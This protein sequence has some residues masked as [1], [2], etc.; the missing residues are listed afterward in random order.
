MALQYEQVKSNSF[1]R[2]L[3]G[4][5]GGNGRGYRTNNHV[6][7]APR[8]KLERGGLESHVH[9][10]P[11]CGVHRQEVPTALALA[12][13]CYIITATPERALITCVRWGLGDSR[14]I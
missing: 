7:N 14:C 10:F 1:L 3:G 12:V 4:G 11:L 6:W 5:G 8:E 13:T 9:R 2:V